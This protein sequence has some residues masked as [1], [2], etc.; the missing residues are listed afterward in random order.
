MHPLDPYQ[1]PLTG[2]RLI[3]ASAGTGKTYTLTLLYL[4]LLLER[5]LGVDQILVV[6]FTR[7]AT[8]E[9]RTRIRGRLREALDT[10]D[11]LESRQEAGSDPALEALL[12]GQE[13][14]QTRQRLND[15]LIRMDEAAIFTIHGFC[16]RVLQE[17]A[18]ASGLPF[19]MELLE[20]EQAIR[21][22]IIQDFW[23]NRFYGVSTEMSRWLRSHWPDP[24]TLLRRL[25]STLSLQ[26]ARVL[27]EIDPRELPP[28]EEQTRLQLE[29]VITL[30]QE[31]R[32]E[33]STILEKD[34]CL[35]RNQKAYRLDMVEQLVGGMDRL[36]EEQTLPYLLPDLLKLLCQDSLERLILKKCATGPSHPFF[37]HFQ[38]FFRL[39]HRYLEQLRLSL[40]QEARSYLQ[41]ELRRRKEEQAQLSYDD[42]LTTLHRALEDQESGPRLAADLARQYP[43]ALVDEFQDTDPLQYR[44]FT[45]ISAAGKGQSLFMIGD[46]KQAIYSF[47][48]ADIF[49]YMGARSRTP[50]DNRYTM[51]TNYRSSAPMVRAIN[52]LFARD[53]PFLFADISFYPVQAA[54]AA[55]G[56]A[57]KVDGRPLPPLTALLLSSER[58][59]V[60]SRSKAINKENATAAAAR[61]TAEEIATLLGLA[62]AGRA[63]M[64]EAGSDPR[65]RPLTAGDIAILV[66]THREAET[67]QQALGYHRIA[68]ICSSR[69]S[70]FNTPQARQLL[71]LLTALLDLSDSGA[72][73]NALASDY[74]GLD[75]VALAELQSGH[76]AWE[77][78]LDRLHHYQQLWQEQGIMP[79]LHQLLARER[80]VARLSAQLGGERKLTNILHLAELLQQAAAG[81][82]GHASL[83]RW[84]T[85][86]LHGPDPEAEPQQLRLES[87]EQLVKIV[88]IHKAKGLEYPLVFLPFLWSSRSLNDQEPLIFHDRA[89]L[90]PVVDLGSGEPSSLRLAKEE[91]QAEAIRLLYVALTRARCCCFFSWGTILGMEQ[92]ALSRLLHPL[93]MEGPLGEGQILQDL[94]LLN[95]EEPLVE[96]QL[97]PKATRPSLL[98][99]QREEAALL[100]RPFEGSIR[101]GWLMTSYS[102]LTAEHGSR[103]PSAPS[104]D[105]DRD[106]QEEEEGLNAFSFPRGPAAGT[107]LHAVLEQVD[108]T[109]PAAS[110]SGII[111]KEFS[112]AGIDEEWIP[113]AQQW[114]EAV[115]AVPLIDT[116][117]LNLVPSHR[118]VDELAF[119]FPLHQLQA[120]RFN[121]VLAGWSIPA[122]IHSA[123]SIDGMMKG[124]IDLVF[125]HGGRYFIVDY[126]SN[127]LGP[128]S[129]CYRQEGL[130]RAMI[131]H[132]YDLQYLIYTLA[133]HRYLQGRLADY[134]YEQHFGGVYYL[135]L[136]GMDP[137]YPPGNGVYA[138]R[139]EQ[140]LIR[141][142]DQCFQG[143]RP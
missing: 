93:S 7:A 68:S 136:R 67:I 73:C 44:I 58:V 102:Q 41:N 51:S 6:T 61:A 39:H 13:R 87:D 89:T 26:Q 123:Q 128:A 23:R 50:A 106:L 108:F 52:R 76:E 47:R 90:A 29:L 119:L 22:E 126:K 70:I 142:L 46:P 113:C 17:N 16:Q 117:P 143:N 65:Q 98:P 49:T 31:Q 115:L 131:E 134:D 80:V 59:P 135:F 1:I 40:L 11:A 139:P 54:P 132:R 55:E 15:A 104:Q 48:G 111:A 97:V 9:L 42:L 45:A 38:Q 27:P 8:D 116:P 18:F 72:V 109:A 75:G 36:A 84:F 105:A 129:D 3:E 107:C 60:S 32:S 56:Q 34:P 114:L 118:R 138:T 121:Q 83:F 2:S 20:S 100:V 127:F 12:A 66:R 30:W 92:A 137:S 141:E 122:L 5:G 86:Q 81:L 94:E 33:L 77:N 78:Q 69:Q 112:R 79:M 99:S 130:A 28:L 74:F 95:R 133:L 10:A 37:G 82:H 140:E 91:H 71:Q 63:T 110:W 88:T 53:T 96:I 64:D 101:P 120:S 85:N 25:S 4:R 57:L 24:E 125:A 35:Q 43:A 14:E 19:A 124:F 103:P 21:L 62:A